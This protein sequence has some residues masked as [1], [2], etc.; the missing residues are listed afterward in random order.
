M[1]YL[2]TDTYD[3]SD[4]I[5]DWADDDPVEKD[6]NFTLPQFEFGGYKVSSHTVTFKTGKTPENYPI[7]L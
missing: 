5:L 6:V 4:L 7:C 1:L 3:T 2:N